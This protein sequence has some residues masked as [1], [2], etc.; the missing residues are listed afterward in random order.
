MTSTSTSKST[1][2]LDILDATQKFGEQWV[3]AVKQ[4]QSIA[5]DV[6]RAFAQAV[7]PTPLRLYEARAAVGLPDVSALTA[8]GFDL[9]A[10]LLA[11]QK[12][13]AVTLANTFAPAKT[14]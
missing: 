2:K 3:S 13:F 12:D 8:Y 14:A 11:A 1:A 5:V 4:S 6:A 7:P 10:E 9:A